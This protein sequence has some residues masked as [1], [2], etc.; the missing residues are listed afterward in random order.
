MSRRNPFIFN[1]ISSIPEII[2]KII[3]LRWVYIFK[4]TLLF[5][6]GSGII[7]E[8]ESEMWK[9][10]FN[11]ALK[12]LLTFIISLFGYSGGAL[13]VLSFI[14]MTNNN[15]WVTLL[16]KPAKLIAVYGTLVAV[17]LAA[18]T[19]YIPVNIRK[20]VQFSKFVSAP[21]VIISALT[22]LILSLFFNINLPPLMINGFALLAI[23][24]TLFRLL[25]R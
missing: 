25:S 20:P 17:I 21:A 19:V 16:E 11:K 4:I 24:G 15:E 7:G 18:I 1:T 10:E 2:V 8:K 22:A 23:A 9:E 14:G 12:Q 13:V 3:I 5:W 6:D